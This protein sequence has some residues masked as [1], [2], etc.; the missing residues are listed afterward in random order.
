M[1]VDGSGYFPALGFLSP[2]SLGLGA[3]GWLRG[4]AAMTS[5]LA[6]AVSGV[7]FLGIAFGA[8]LYAYLTAPP[9]D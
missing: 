9:P 4:Q 2:W 8:E 3:T 1:I 7:V 5:L 6:V